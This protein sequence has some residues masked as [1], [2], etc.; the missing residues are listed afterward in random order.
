V[1]LAAARTPSRAET[2]A[3]AVLKTIAETP[4][5]PGTPAKAAQPSNRENI[6][7]YCKGTPET[8]GMLATAGTEVRFPD[9][10]FQCCGS[11]KFWYG[12]GSGDPYL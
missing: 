11:M 4:T 6:R 1:K 12:S 7:N 10:F 9:S 8:T 3:K 2:P 5:K